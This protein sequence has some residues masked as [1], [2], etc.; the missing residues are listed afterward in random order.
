M[1]SGGAPTQGSYNYGT[2]INMAGGVFTALQQAQ[3]GRQQQQ[4]DNFLANQSEAQARA[5][6]LQ[7]ALD[8]AQLQEQGNQLA[9]RQLA[10]MAGN[11]VDVGSVTM[12]DILSDTAY[13]VSLDELAVKYGAN[14][15]IQDLLNQANLQ[16]YAGRNA[17]QTGRMS[18]FNT[19]L[20]TAGQ[21]YDSWYQYKKTSAGAKT[22]SGSTTSDFVAGKRTL[23]NTKSA[24]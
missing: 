12:Q 17:A 7:S 21:V 5:V 14:L 24:R 2:Y 16:R 11:G 4:Y 18:A 22:G 9:A 13:K 8:T 20:G 6:G 3:Q 23:P 15:Q 1:G 10:A 19:L